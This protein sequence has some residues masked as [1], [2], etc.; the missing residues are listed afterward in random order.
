MQTFTRIPSRD[1]WARFKRYASWVRVLYPSDVIISDDVFRQLSYATSGG[2]VC[3]Q[4][5]HL[6]WTSRYGW[7]HVQQFISPYLV[8]VTFRGDGFAE[9]YAGQP[10][11]SA[12]S[13]LPTTY[14]ESLVLDE[15]P[16]FLPI[17]FAV[18]KVVQRLSTHFKRLTV[19]S[20]SDAAWAYLASLPNLESFWVSYTPPVDISKLISHENAFPALEHVGIKVDNTSQH[21]SSLFSLLK[22]SPLRRVTVVTNPGNWG[23][24]VAIQVTIAII[25]AG[26]QRSVDALIFTKFD[27]TNL[28]LV[29]CLGVFSSLKT[30][31]CH[32]RCRGG[33]CVFPLTDPDIER[34]A[35]GLPQ[36]V[37]I[38]AGHACKYGHPNT[39]IR[40]MISLSTHCLSLKE[41]RLPC[42]LTNVT[43]DAKTESGEPDPRLEIRSP[44][45]L[46]TLAFGWV[47]MPSLD[48]LKALRV[49]ILAL[50]HLFPYLLPSG[51]DLRIVWEV[52]L[53]MDMLENPDVGAR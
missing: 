6:S 17:R 40:S 25:E 35:R 28:T 19:P 21:W 38:R 12:I 32:T 43:E 11:A 4:L 2:P 45:T 53:D 52:V 24:D 37:V 41:L 34:L 30:L 31:R 26:L 1:E 5:R 47:A 18:S 3:P 49:V 39:T 48:D 22:S 10:L 9:R 29:S 33:Q 42:D 51:R 8:S 14:L 27:P 16:R 20:L 44:C 50:H 15:T 46:K 7:E 36:L 23:D 13:L